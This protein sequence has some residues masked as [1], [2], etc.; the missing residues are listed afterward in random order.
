MRLFELALQAS[1]AAKLQAEF[2]LDWLLLVGMHYLGV[3]CSRMAGHIFAKT[4]VEVQW[5]MHTWVKV[6]IPVIVLNLS[7]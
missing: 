3:A 6:V 5:Y 1:Q 2:A 7:L 4:L